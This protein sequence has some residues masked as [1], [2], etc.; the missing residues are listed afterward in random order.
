MGWIR[1]GTSARR[2]RGVMRKAGQAGVPD[3]TRCQKD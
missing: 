3:A 1:T 2:Y